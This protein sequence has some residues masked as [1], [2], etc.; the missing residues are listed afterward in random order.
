MAA[1]TEDVNKQPMVAA[2][3]KQQAIRAPA[4]EDVKKQSMVAAAAEM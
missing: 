2:A 4:S 3:R 1:T